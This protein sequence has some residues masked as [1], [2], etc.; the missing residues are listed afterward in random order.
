MKRVETRLA[1]DAASLIAVRAIDARHRFYARGTVTLAIVIATAL[2]GV[3]VI[4]SISAPLRRV[5]STLTGGS[6]EVSAAA[7]QVSS[8][9]QSLAA[10]SSEQAASLEETSASIEEI[11]SQARRSAENAD[12]ARALANDTR[13][14]TEHGTQQMREMVVAMGDI[15]T[16]SNNI[17]KI[18]K[19]ID[20]IAFQTN[21][22]ALNA[23]VE[24][25]RAGEHG[26]G[27]AVV[28]D[29]VRS[30]ARRAADAAKETATR[31]D[32]SIRKSAAGTEISNRVATGLDGIADRTR[33]VNELVVEIATAAKEQ[34]QGLA[35]VSTAVT[36]MDKITQS[37]AAS[38][39]ETAAA[40]EELNAQAL[41]LRD[42]VAELQQLIA[43]A[44][45]RASA[46]ASH[47]ARSLSPRTP[48]VRRAPAAHALAE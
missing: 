33:Q 12:R 26:A 6:N 19:T 25:A 48:I 3:W 46:S 5:I 15:Q 2:F 9:S 37:S 24:A 31:I 35:Q 42:N 45:P 22:L 16:S 44:A 23:A 41:L 32:D 20:E 11:N 47:A 13:A 7:G 28:A 14:A 8:A 18:I 10:G 29:E 36:Q 4:R 30:L 27:F 1:E 38:A 39:E 34:T 21:I 40:A 17:A 43:G